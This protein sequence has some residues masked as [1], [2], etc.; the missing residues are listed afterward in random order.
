MSFINYSSECSC[1]SFLLSV[2]Q[3]LQPVISTLIPFVREENAKNSQA[4]FL[5]KAD[6][7]VPVV[8]PKQEYFIYVQRFGPPL[9]GV[10]DETALNKIREE[11][12]KYDP[13]AAPVG[14]ATNS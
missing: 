3:Q 9:Q 5:G 7:K 8:N 14:P 11:L 10:F 13:P 1:D 2:I 6:V 12:G 4:V